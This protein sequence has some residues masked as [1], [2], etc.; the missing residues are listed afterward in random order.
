MSAYY[1]TVVLLDSLT[2]T[3]F[4][5]SCPDDT[6]LSVIYMCHLSYKIKDHNR[7]VSLNKKYYMLNI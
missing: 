4:Q 3:D 1:V 2:N 6:Q 5:V 7:I